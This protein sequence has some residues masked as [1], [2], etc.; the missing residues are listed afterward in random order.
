MK[1]VVYSL[2]EDGTIPEYIVDGG[3]FHSPSG[4]L[5]GIAN[6]EAP[7]TALTKDLF[8]EY[9][10]SFCPD[11]IDPL[12]DEVTDAATLANNF[13]TNKMSG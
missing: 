10:L 6:D 9:I 1:L 7:E 8:L 4:M 13:W 3:Y 2:M 5:V 12:T 11:F